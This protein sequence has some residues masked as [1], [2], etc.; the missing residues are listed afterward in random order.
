MSREEINAMKPM[1]K[2]GQE[3]FACCGK[4]APHIPKWKLSQAL[5]D[6]KT[7][8]DPAAGFASGPSVSKGAVQDGIQ[9]NHNET[10]VESI[11]RIVR[12]PRRLDF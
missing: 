9:S 6:L 8:K 3:V 5:R 7:R 2:Q 4:R 12:P 1:I 11:R 10:F